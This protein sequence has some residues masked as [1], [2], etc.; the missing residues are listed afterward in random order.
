M[1]PSHDPFGRPVERRPD[2]AARGNATASA[3][4]ATTSAPDPPRASPRT[5]SRYRALL[6]ALAGGVVVTAATMT[7]AVGWARDLPKTIAFAVAQE[8]FGERSLLHPDQARAG[9]ARALARVG[10]DERVTAVYLDDDRISVWTRRPDGYVA[11]VDT[12]I[13]GETERRDTRNRAE[14]RGVPVTDLG[15]ID[16]AD[17]A[18][19]A[20]ARWREL[21]TPPDPP[22]VRLQID[23]GRLRSWLIAFSF[24]Q[25]AESERTVTVGLDG[26]RER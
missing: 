8:P 10:A 7:F 17:G 26:S 16:V 12:T 9:V 11:I 20:H 22:M 4:G 3:P 13:I 18:R 14:E 5:G 1:T 2:D 23:D 15:A 25:V 21:G 6:A 19:A 24:S